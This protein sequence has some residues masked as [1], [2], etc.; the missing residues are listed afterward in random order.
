M[1]EFIQLNTFPLESHGTIWDGRG[2]SMP[3]SK[4]NT[5]CLILD[6]LAPKKDDGPDYCLNYDVTK[7][8]QYRNL[9]EK[10]MLEYLLINWIKQGILLVWEN[11]GIFISI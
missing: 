11:D 2:S 7:K 10:K 3:K 8:P 4:F 6:R 9:R 5:S 1:I